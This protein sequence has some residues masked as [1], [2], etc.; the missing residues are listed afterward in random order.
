MSL[1]RAVSKIAVIPYRDRQRCGDEINGEKNNFRAGDPKKV[2]VERCRHKRR[3]RDP[4]DERNTP[5]AGFLS[6]A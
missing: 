3:Q 1:K 6:A 5:P 4:D 2:N